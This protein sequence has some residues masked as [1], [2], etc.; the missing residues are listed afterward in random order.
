MS[1]EAVELLKKAA[2]D[3]KALTANVM[4]ALHE[5]LLFAL[6][7]KYLDLDRFNDLFIEQKD[8]LQKHDLSDR[9]RQGVR[10]LKLDEICYQRSSN[11]HLSG[12][13]SVLSSMR[14]CGHSLV[15][16]VEGQA[17]R[18]TVYLGLSQFD[19]KPLL[20]L[21]E[22]ISVYESAWRANFPGVRIEPVAERRVAEISAGIG[23]SKHCGFLTGI[24]SLKRE[25]AGFDFVQ[26][27]ER[28]IRALRGRSYYWVSV[29]DPI[30]AGSLEQAI[31]SCQQ[32]TGDIHHLVKTTLTKGVSKSKTVMAGMFGTTGTGETNGTARSVTDSES[33][34]HTDGTTQQYVEDH[35][36]LGK[37]GTVAGMIIG[38]IIYPG[39]GSVIGAT[40]GSCFGSI[41][42]NLG[43]AITGKAGFAKTISDS[44]TNTKAFTDT[45][46]EAVSKQLAGGGFG[47]FGMTWSRTTSVTQEILNRKAE[48][49]EELLR[50][51]EKRLM[52]GRATGMWT[53]GHYFGSEDATTYKM[54][55]GALRSLFSG[56]DSQYEPPRITGL[57]ADATV[58]LRRFANIYLS[59]PNDQLRLLFKDNPPQGLVCA[60]HPLGFSFNGVGTPLSTP[61]LAI[62]TPL[63]TQEAE[64]ISVT[65]RA[66]FG[67]NAPVDE[68]GATLTLGDVLDHGD[69]T[70][71]KIRLK[72]QNLPK[73]VGVFGLTGSGKT[74]TVQSLLRQLWDKHK[75]PFLVIE[76][77]K[78][79]YRRLT[80]SGV[81]NDDLVVITAGVESPMTC[82][83]RLN[84][85]SFTPPDDT[86]RN[87]VYLLTHIDRLRSIFNASFPMY[88]SMPYLLEEALLEVY[89][90]KG[91][92][93]T[94]SQNRHVL[95]N[96]PRLADF[97]PSLSDLHLKI[98]TVV[99]RKGYWV[100]QERNLSAALKTRIA[101]LMAGSKG[102]MLN[103]R[104]SFSDKDMF[105]RPMVIELRHIGD[106]D[107]KAFLM[108]LI[109][110]RL[111]EYRESHASTSGDFC[112][113][114]VIEEAHRLL[115]D[116]PTAGAGMESANMRGKG[117]SS[118]IDMLSEIR[119][120]GQGVAVVDQVPG[121]L[122][123]YIVKGTG[124]KIV[125]RLLAKDDREMVGHT[126][127]LDDDQMADLGLLDCGQCIFH[128]DGVRK[129][130]FCKVTPMKAATATT[131]I[132]ASTGLNP[133]TLAFRN[134]NTE[135]IDSQMAGPL[136]SALPMTGLKAF[137]DAL[138]KAMSAA[139]FSS[140]PEAGR[141]LDNLNHGIFLSPPDKSNYRRFVKAMWQHVATDMWSFSGGEF[142]NFLHWR[143]EGEQ[144]LGAWL[145]GKPLRSIETYQKAAHK[146]YMRTA[147]RDLVASVYDQLITRFEVV[148]KVAH[149]SAGGNPPSQAIGV[150]IARA[151]VDL[152]PPGD[153]NPPN[154]L[155]SKLAFAIATRISK[156]AAQQEIVARIA[157][158]NFK[159]IHQPTI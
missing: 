17:D 53:V 48:Y 55:Q 57:P 37:V 74:T 33:T 138:M 87:G 38:S 82:P 156:Q 121:R 101:S 117:V 19:D 67:V 31:K 108:G 42:S 149:H 155:F 47:S 63:P 86:G 5:I 110:M 96:D 103:C 131:T 6:E 61:E 78:S 135:C 24:P 114:L 88:A 43:D 23:N 143:D 91:W 29:A 28:L 104:Q 51:H 85:F 146:Y 140:G 11:F 10:L 151:L 127:G 109:I 134:A 152:L 70:R 59:F 46:S 69:V 124:T 90:D 76:P 72:M 20:P 145:E 7:R 13:E 15:F 123:P 27:L 105:E 45:A 122:H 153:F 97:F 12:V 95:R 120:Y 154:E 3:Q 148:L 71:Q 50:T 80:S 68:I 139:V 83:L 54:G 56:M 89:E 113:L 115:A 130:F 73:H 100:E 36:R 137:H 52:T 133:G 1:K 39:I 58:L 30:G 18:A 40:V 107:E 22:A 111:Y 65:R 98:D 16:V 150:G 32:L 116:V 106:D 4:P 64:G 141:F 125:H 158:E 41:V 79:E 119:A 66:Q 93:L 92:D 159:K 14:E 75:I 8:Q 34:T 132:T 157:V 77:A 94:S 81:L 49:C 126:M 112:H 60:T 99:K 129:A 44:V 144:L 128:Q 136:A 25:E 21:D 147:E 26:G 142:V 35:Q 102:A 62:A 2:S 118:F 9:L 84:P